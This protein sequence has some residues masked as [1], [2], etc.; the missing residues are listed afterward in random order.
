LAAIQ[1]LDMFYFEY[2]YWGGGNIWAHSFLLMI[3]FGCL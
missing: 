3:C 1:F 2:N